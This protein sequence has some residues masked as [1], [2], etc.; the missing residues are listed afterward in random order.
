MSWFLLLAPAAD[1]WLELFQF[2]RKKPHIILDRLSILGPLDPLLS[3][4]VSIFFVL[5]TTLA[6]MV[7]TVR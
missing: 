5:G 1:L 4:F 7:A 3:P 2:D 6:G